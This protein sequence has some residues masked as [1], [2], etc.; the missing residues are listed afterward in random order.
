MKLDEKLRR[1]NEVLLFL[2]DAGNTR[3]PLAVSS[4]YY[5]TYL[6]SSIGPTKSQF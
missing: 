3:Y 6:K 5:P 1:V 4:D 2:V